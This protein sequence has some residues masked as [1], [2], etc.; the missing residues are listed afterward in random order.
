MVKDF[1]KRFSLPLAAVGLAAFNTIGM[2]MNPTMPAL[3]PSVVRDSVRKGSN[4]TIIYKN[5]FAKKGEQRQVSSLFLDSLPVISARDTIKAPDSL[6]IIDPFKYRWY[7]ATLDSAT[8]AWVR[9]SLRMTGDSLVWPRIDSIYSADSTIRAR[10]AFEKWFSSL[11][12]IGKK[13]YFAEKKGEIEKRRTDSITAV[14][15]SIKAVR[16]SIRESTPRILETFALPDTMQYKRLVAWTLD[17]RYSK[18]EPFIPDTSYNHWFHDFPFRREDVNATW[19]GVAGSPVQPYNYFRRRSTEH[20]SFYEPYEAWSHSPSTIPL[21]NTKVPYTELAYWGTLFANS[22]KS[23]DNLHIFTSQNIF[24][25]LNFT[26]QYDRYG[27]GGMLENETTKNKNFAATFNYL[28]K[29]YMMNAG[30]IF[31]SISRGENGGLTDNMWIR[32]TTVDARE[33]DVILSNAKTEIKKNTVFLDQELRIPLD[34]MGRL[35]KKKTRTD[36]LASSEEGLLEDSAHKDVTTA[37]IGH[38]SEYS[39]YR[40]LYTDQ[41][42]AADSLARAFYNDRFNY[43]P[44]SSRD[45]VRTAKLENRVFIR[46]QPWSDDGIVSKLN[47]GLGNRIQTFYSIDPTFLRRSSTSKWNSTFLYGGVE[48]QLRNYIRW[49]ANGEFIFAGKEAGDF[50]I[51][52]SA[53]L[54]F[55][56]FR[57]ARKSPVSITLNFDTS[58]K[59]PDFYHQ[60]YYSN[61]YSWENGFDKISVTRIGGRIDIPYWKLSLAAG[62]ALLDKNIYFDATGTVRQNDTPMSI[63]TL[64]LS[65]NLVLLGNF[66]HLDNRA[67]L[68]WSSNKDVVPLPA[69]ALNLRYYIQFNIVKDVL[70]VQAG[71][72][73]LWNSS[74]YAPGW[75]PAVGSFYNQARIKYNNGPSFDVFVNMQWKRACIFVKLENLGMGW[76]MD[77]ADYFSAHHYI[78]TQKALKLGMFWPFYMPSGRARTMSES[79]SAGGSGG[80]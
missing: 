59:E 47:A 17:R 76:P 31:N 49:N 58:L 78:R 4:D 74:W 56:P 9:D 70:Q 67:L 66:L 50:S 57:K 19:L 10:E 27:G 5:P 62:Y 65:K 69:L 55:Y 48:G 36:T 18:T 40:K 54:S 64:A 1:L 80:R 42:P 30:Y 29:K 77:K 3:Q 72:D 71:A 25:E 8:H 12:K 44:T 75:N 68:Q 53:N 24:P 20:V 32:D 23:S 73:G 45:S 14:K 26:L 37:F 38:S 28:G 15:D 11:D 2:N 22:E 51:D 6:R 41:I 46:L 39:T 21:Y 61:H 60:H 63:A 34:F 33:I 43:N 52:A 7:A 16:D 79:M 35:L 13:K